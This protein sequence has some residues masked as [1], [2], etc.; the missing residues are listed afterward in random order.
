MNLDQLNE[1]MR[2]FDEHFR[3][4]G[5]AMTEKERLFSRV[6]KLNE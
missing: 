6:V 5:K 1:N 4:T 3:Q 2:K